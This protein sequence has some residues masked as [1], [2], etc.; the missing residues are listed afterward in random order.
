MTRAKK[1]IQVTK[2]YKFIIID[3]SNCVRLGWS[4]WDTE[5]LEYRF[6]NQSPKFSIHSVLHPG[7]KY[8]V[9]E[10][11]QKFLKP[12]DSANEAY[13]TKALVAKLKSE[14]TREVKDLK[15]RKEQ[16]KEYVWAGK[17]YVDMTETYKQAIQRV[18]RRIKDQRKH[19]KVWKKKQMRLQ[20][21]GVYTYLELLR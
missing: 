12:G 5:N 1:K 8:R 4:D 15:A 10:Y 3:Y 11:F 9:R 17:G 2:E 19:L 21:A 13:L 14:L 6:V 18:E 20:D 16:L 7:Q